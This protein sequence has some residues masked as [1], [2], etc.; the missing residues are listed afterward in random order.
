[1]KGNEM[2]WISDLFNAGTDTTTTTSSVPD[3]AVPYYQNF[4]QSA[5]NLAQMPY[6]AYGGQTVAGLNPFTVQ[7]LN[8]QAQRAVQGSPV[9]NAASG[10][11]QKTL[12]GGYLNNNPYLAGMVDLAAQDVTRAYAPLDARSGSFGNSGVNYDRSKAFADAALHIRANDYSQERNRMMAG[13]SQAPGIAN[14]DYVDATALQQAGQGFQQNQQAQMTDQYQRWQ[15]AQQYPYKQLQTMG[16][17]L[18][19]NPGTTTTQQTPGTSPAATGLGTAASL[20]S[21]GNTKSPTVICTELHRQGFMP[22]DVYALDQ[23]Y[24]SM[25]AA[26]DPQV[27]AGY[28]RLATPVVKKM[29]QS[30]LFAGIVWMLAKPWAQEM[31]HQMGNGKGSAIGKLIMTIGYPLCLVAGNKAAMNQTA[32]V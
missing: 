10:E 23:A 8:A 29:Q 7:G 3:W 15:E 17:G 21:L 32:G 30:R 2:T 20:Y 19:F 12:S 24:G 1:M 14:Q 25:L 5:Q 11:L 22:D 27:Y 31:A 9:M 16:Y 13:V 4:M 6:Q 28:I 18:G 26:N